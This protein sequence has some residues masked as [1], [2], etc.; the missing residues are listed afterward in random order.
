M[1]RC[2]VR[3]LNMGDTFVIGMCADSKDESEFIPSAVIIRFVDA[4]SRNKQAN[5]KDDRSDESMPKPAE[6]PGR[7][8]VQ[9]FV[10]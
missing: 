10:F 4:H 8:C 7:S 1:R 9:L 5:E 2:S 6:K 3:F